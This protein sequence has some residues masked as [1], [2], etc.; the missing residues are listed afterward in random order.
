M[1]FVDLDALIERE[2]QCTVADIIDQRGENFFRRLESQTLQRL[3]RQH[4]GDYVFAIGGGGV[5]SEANRRLILSSG[6]SV[7][8]SCS[9]KELY[10]R[11][12]RHQNNRPLL[13]VNPGD[14]ETP[15]Q[16]LQRRIRELLAHRERYYCQAQVRHS[17]SSRDDRRV[18][19][20]L[21]T[22]LRRL[23]DFD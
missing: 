15:R 3:L 4:P 16:A 19:Q 14:G 20:N 11:L 18:V 8:L 7:Y 22:K 6:V 2:H 17:T 9:I 23:H 1:R 5:E 13:R 12:K 21:I 10:R